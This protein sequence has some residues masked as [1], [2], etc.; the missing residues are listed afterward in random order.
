ML[1][2]STLFEAFIEGDLGTRDAYPWWTTIWG[3]R[4]GS[5]RDKSLSKQIRK[6][7]GE[8]TKTAIKEGDFDLL[9]VLS[10][11]LEE[12]VAFEQE[13]ANVLRA[14]IYFAIFE[15]NATMAAFDRSD[16]LE[17]LK[18]VLDVSISAEELELELLKL[19]LADQIPSKLKGDKRGKRSKRSRK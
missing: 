17:W 13:P 8:V 14:N 12:T 7:L 1:V 9:Q 18:K 16:V 6:S 5:W 4:S 11:T 15:L 3:L 10:R 19:K 2:G